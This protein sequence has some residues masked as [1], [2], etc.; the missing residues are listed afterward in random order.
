MSNEHLVLYDVRAESEISLD[1]EQEG[2]LKSSIPTTLVEDLS[3]FGFEP[4]T[5]CV[6]VTS[7]K[8]K[9]WA[10]QKRYRAVH[11]ENQHYCT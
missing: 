7:Y 9:L 5:R 8:F 6:D 11:N 2:A 4:G 3:R 10:Q 1:P